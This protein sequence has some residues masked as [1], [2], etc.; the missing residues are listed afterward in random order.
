VHPLLLVAER[1]E[2]DIDMILGADYL[3]G[4]HLWLSPYTKRVFIEQPAHG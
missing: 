3:K 4:H 2:P 1:A